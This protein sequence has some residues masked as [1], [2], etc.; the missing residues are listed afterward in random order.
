MS[1]RGG[2]STPG[3]PVA[4][5]LYWCTPEAPASRARATPVSRQLLAYPV[6]DRIQYQFLIAPPYLLQ[7]GSEQQET[8]SLKDNSR[9]CTHL[10]PNQIF[11]R[12]HLFC[13]GPPLF[14]QFNF[15]S[16]S[17]SKKGSTPVKRANI[18]SL[19]TTGETGWHMKGC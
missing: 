9:A 2:A 13:N 10:S 11:L 14:Q 12:L 4:R 6:P 1:W 16:T 15:L 18:L 3:L 8:H 5:S 19:I 17:P 7:Q